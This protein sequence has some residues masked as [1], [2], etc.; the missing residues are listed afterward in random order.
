MSERDALLSA[1]LAD[2]ADDVSRLV[3][4]DWLEETAVPVAVAR[5]RFIRAQVEL[6]GDVPAQHFPESAA[7][8]TREADALA[9]RWARAWLKEL[10]PP[11]AKALSKQRLGTGWFRRGFVD[12]VTLS[13]D[14]FL[15]AAA[16]LFA[17]APLTELHVN[18]GYADVSAVVASPYLRR[19][20]VVRLSGGWDGDRIARRLAARGDLGAVPDLDLSGCRLTDAGAADLVG[21]AAL[22]RLAVLRVRWNRL[23]A[24]GIWTLANAPA[25]AALETLDVTG[26]YGVRGWTSAAPAVRGKRLVY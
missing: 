5:A 26:N 16:G 10:P 2:P 22:E 19:L 18:G 7:A 9:G 21:G 23:T 8:L 11:A 17:A 1:I 14:V 3:Y 12:G 4:A 20:R 15:W 25:L 6:A 24:A 13:A